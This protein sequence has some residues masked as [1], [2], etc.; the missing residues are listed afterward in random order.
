MHSEVIWEYFEGADSF[1]F[2]FVIVES[3]VDAESHEALEVTGLQLTQLVMND[4]S[5]AIRPL[6]TS[7]VIVIL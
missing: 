1:V 7:S 4:P 6:L 2:M 3:E 5:A